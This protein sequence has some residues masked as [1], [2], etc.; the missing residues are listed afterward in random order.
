MQLSKDCP[1]RSLRQIIKITMVDHIRS[2]RVQSSDWISVV[3]RRAPPH[4]AVGRYSRLVRWPHD[5]SV[6][7]LILGM[8]VDKFIIV[9]VL[10]IDDQ[11]IARDIGDYRCIVTLWQGFGI[12]I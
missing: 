8:R 2:Q 1:S 5:A 11:G 7:S 6:R 9:F 12:E 4:V 3:P 10:K